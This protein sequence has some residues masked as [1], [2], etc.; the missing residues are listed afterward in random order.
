MNQKFP[1]CHLCQKFLTYHLYQTNPMYLPNHQNQ[2]LLMYHHYLMCQKFPMNQPYQKLPK[3]RLYQ[4]Y[5]MY[6]Y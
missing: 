3:C 4:R 6:H 5:P 1:M 2:K